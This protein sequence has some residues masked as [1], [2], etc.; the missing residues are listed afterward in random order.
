MANPPLN[1]GPAPKVT[2][3]SISAFV[4]SFNCGIVAVDVETVHAIVDLS[5]LL[6][7]LILISLIGLAKNLIGAISFLSEKNELSLERA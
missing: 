7:M 3:Q 2:M 1:K 5:V 4:Y 6:G